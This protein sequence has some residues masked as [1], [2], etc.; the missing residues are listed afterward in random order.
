MKP[1]IIALIALAL[2]AG[3]RPSSDEDIPGLPARATEDH[4]EFARTFEEQ[5]AV[6]AFVLYDEQQGRLI[7]YNPERS[8]QG[9]PPA[10]TFKILNALIALDTGVVSPDEVVPWDGVVRIGWDKWQQDH[11]LRSAFQYSVLWFYQEM[12]RR[13]GR[14]R[15]QFYVDAVGYGNRDIST[16]IDTFWLDG[17]LR[18]SPVHQ[19]A[20]L[21]RLYHDDLPFSPQ[22]MATVRDIMVMEETDAYVLRGKTGWTIVD[23]VNHGWMVGYVE[24]GE[25]VYFF[26]TNVESAAADYDMRAARR[27]IT[28]GILEALGVR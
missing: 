12:A 1:P 9:F 24:Q 23:G 26:A 16:E 6:G 4:P 10:S 19:V 3:C 22:T 13:I 18:I 15:M 17:S 7:R 8:R 5:G 28:F 2:L 14:E 27:T 20:F 25:D 11:T 21:R